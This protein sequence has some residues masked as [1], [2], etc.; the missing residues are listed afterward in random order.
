VTDA[1]PVRFAS[2]LRPHLRALRK[3]RALTQA[4]VGALIGVSQA[5]IAEIE[6]NPGLVNFEQILQLL[7]ALGVTLSLR[8][9]AAAPAADDG[10]PQ[11]KTKARAAAK[12]S[13]AA[14]RPRKPRALPS[15]QTA[16]APPR[17]ILIRPKKGSW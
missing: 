5:R 15:G 12:S 8:E 10:A 1:Y 11:T 3:K 17:K 9:A 14:T 13:S 7:A 16:P 6:A 4:Q 2:Q